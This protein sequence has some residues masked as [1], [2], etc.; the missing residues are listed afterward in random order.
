MPDLHFY[1]DDTLEHAFKIENLL[2]KI[3]E[4]EPGSK[5]EDP[6]P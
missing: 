4:D 3:K 1:I 2:K 6:K 5:E